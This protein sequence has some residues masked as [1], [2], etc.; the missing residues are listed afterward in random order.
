MSTRP[1][2]YSNY[3]E[4]LPLEIALYVDA[5]DMAQRVKV[6][7]YACLAHVYP[8]DA[9]QAFVTSAL[10]PSRTSYPQ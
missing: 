6:S 3:D 4:K 1:V 7:G 8:L 2:T 5:E 10:Q 9:R